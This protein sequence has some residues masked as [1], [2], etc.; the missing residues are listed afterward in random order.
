MFIRDPFTACPKCGQEEFGVASVSGNSYLKRC[1]AC[2]LSSHLDLPPVKK[3]IVYVDQNGISNMM[4]ALNPDAK[5]HERAL[6]NPFWLEL[7][8]RL[9][10][11]GSMQL[12]LCPSSDTHGLESAASPD[13]AAYKRLYEHLSHGTRFRDL[14]SIR[15]GQ[16]SEAVRNEVGDTDQ[17][18]WHADRTEAFHNSPDTWCDWFYFTFTQTYLRDGAEEHR[19]MLDQLSSE[20]NSVM[21][22]YGG[23]TTREYRVLLEREKRAMP[24]AIAQ[25]AQ[26]HLQHMLEVFSG[27]RA[28]D[29]CEVQ[30][31][32]VLDYLHVAHSAF[33][34][35]GLE[36][37]KA[38]R[39]AR[40]L[41]K[42]VEFWFQIPF[43]RIQCMLWAA[44]AR[45]A[46]SGK[47]KQPSRGM[48]DDVKTIS[49]LLPYCD[50][51]FL[52]NECAALLSEGPLRDEIDYGTQ[53]FSQNSK[54]ELL[55][56]LDGLKGSATPAHL[57][58]LKDVYG[59]R[60]ITPNRRLYSK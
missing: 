47:K 2:N 25:A 51:M 56:Y 35:C 18:A 58:A 44:A 12:L 27:R 24:R 31:P 34:R 10:I 45:K 13:F 55:E 4:K 59:D 33:E 42:D 57:A 36:S 7:Y 54:T 16:F 52:D 40:D 38:R 1:R 8:D 60:Y 30:G 46:A 6:E 3:K 20:I 49:V 26:E 50:A 11:S 48:P 43:N 21:D 29:L 19:Y 15:L 39:E 5:G 17:G 9:D 22:N 28:P 41:V 23:S 53:I 14:H 32:L 37:E